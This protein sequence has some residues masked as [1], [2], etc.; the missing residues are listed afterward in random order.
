MTEGD[1]TL[2]LLFKLKLLQDYISIKTLILG[3]QLSGL[4]ILIY[5][6]NSKC[7]FELF[8]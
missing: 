3:V 1:F 2:D 7:H 5:V 8:I 6:R 4:S